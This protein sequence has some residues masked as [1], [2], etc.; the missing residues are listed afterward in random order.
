MFWDGTR[1]IDER[2]QL[3]VST[4]QPARAPVRRRFR[5]PMVAAMSGFVIAAVVG[6]QLGATPTVTLP[7]DADNAAARQVWVEAPIVAGEGATLRAH[8]LA[9]NAVYMLKWDRYGRSLRLIWTDGDGKVRARFRVPTDARTGSHK[10]TLMRITRAE[11]ST[12]VRAGNKQPGISSGAAPIM[13]L[14]L[15]VKL[16][17][18]GNGKGRNKPANPSQPP[19][20][21]PAITQAPVPSADPTATPVPDPTATPAPTP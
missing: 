15:S 3:T 11:A 20:G 21:S 1:W 8:H 19:L 18:G 5:V 17:R 14:S 9:R 12:Y 2:E 16:D 4:V 6:A 13:T 10:L 7:E